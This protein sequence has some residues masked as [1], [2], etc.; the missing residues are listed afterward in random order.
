MITKKYPNPNE[1]YPIKNN[2]KAVFIKNIVNS[3][4]IIVGDFTIGE[5]SKKDFNNNILYTF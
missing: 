1:L 4:K 5:T 3:E 2:K